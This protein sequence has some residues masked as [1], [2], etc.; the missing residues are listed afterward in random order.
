MKQ[1]RNSLLLHDM[2]HIEQDGIAG[3]FPTADVTVFGAKPNM[4]PS[5]NNVERR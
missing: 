2:E 1:A 3:I 4:R 5:K